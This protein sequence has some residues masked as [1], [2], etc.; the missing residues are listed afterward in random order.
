VHAI[1]EAARWAPT[2]HNMQN[3]EIAI[4]DAEPT[5]AK[6]A[7]VHSG[8]SREF[9]RENYSSARS[10][11]IAITSTCAQRP[12]ARRRGNRSRD[13]SARCDRRERELGGK[14]LHEHRHQ[15]GG[16]H[17]PDERVSEFGAA[18]TLVAKSPES[19]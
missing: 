13:S 12:S 19:T 14:A 18:S 17:D 15:I 8:T 11:A 6:I 10:V 1:L 9:V 3:F 5:L 16:D 4:V 2:A 7:R